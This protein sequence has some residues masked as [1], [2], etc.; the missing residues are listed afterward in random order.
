V[1]HGALVTAELG[2]LIERHNRVSRR[3]LERAALA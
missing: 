3:M 2:P 1:N